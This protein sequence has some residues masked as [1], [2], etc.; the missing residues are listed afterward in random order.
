MFQPSILGPRSGGTHT[1]NP[2]VESTTKCDADIRGRFCSNI[3]LEGGNTIFWFFDKTE[4]GDAGT[5]FEKDG[6]EGHGSALEEILHLYRGLNTCVVII[7]PN[8]EC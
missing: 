8:L 6:G 4:K 5:Y 3:V 2:T 7:T 1:G